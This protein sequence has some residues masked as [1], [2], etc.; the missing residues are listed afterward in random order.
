MEAYREC[1]PDFGPTLAAEKLAERIARA[2]VAVTVFERAR[3]LGGRLATRREG[4][5]AFDHGAQ[6]LTARGQAF[7][8][9]VEAATHTGAVTAWKPRIREDE[10]SWDAPIDDWYVGVPGM[11]AAVR[12]MSASRAATTDVSIVASP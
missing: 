1:Y 10:R 8:R 9:F 4:N 12:P 7:S 5:L 2:D 11:S 6:Y 3:G